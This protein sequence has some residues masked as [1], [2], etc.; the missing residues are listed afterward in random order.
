MVVGAG[1]VISGAALCITG[2]ATT[3]VAFFGMTGKQVFAWGAIMYDVFPM[4]I[5]P[6]LGL[7]METLEYPS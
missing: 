5:A 7:E 6:F 3:T 4:I 2:S 1:A